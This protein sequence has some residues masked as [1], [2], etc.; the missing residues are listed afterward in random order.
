MAK[1]PPANAED[2][3]LIPGL[4]GS[5]EVGNDNLLQYSCLENSTEGGAWWAKVYGVAKSWT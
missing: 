3:G 4:G 1:N 5:P 2:V